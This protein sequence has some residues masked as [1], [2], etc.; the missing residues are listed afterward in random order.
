MLKIIKIQK[1]ATI[2]ASQ[3]IKSPSKF[4]KPDVHVYLLQDVDNVGKKGEII[5]V[6]SESARQYYLPFKLAYYVPRDMG[7]P[8]LPDNW[9]PIESATIQFEKILPVFGIEG[10][11][12]EEVEQDVKTV[13][14]KLIEAIH[15]SNYTK[16]K[17]LT[18]L[19]FCKSC[20][21][22]GQGIKKIYGSVNVD[23]IIQEISRLYDVS[24]DK[25][26]VFLK[27]KIKT[28]GK[29]EAIIKIQQ[30]NDIKIT[31]NVLAL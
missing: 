25:S 21:E 11:T 18:D 9:A 15:L 1:F 12:E 13:D 22:S 23:D 7:K 24:I 2:G 6:P 20:I 17:D 10:Y 8:I 4:R 26:Q 16:L 29:F 27:D 5:L 14:N 30:Y 31:V 19:E 28:T 3:L